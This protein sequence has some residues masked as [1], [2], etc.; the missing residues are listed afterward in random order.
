MMEQPERTR[1][2]AGSSAAE[3]REGLRRLAERAKEAAEKKTDHA[4]AA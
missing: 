4:F 2:L 1:R 3:V